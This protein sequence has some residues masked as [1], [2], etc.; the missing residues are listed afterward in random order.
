ME[1][2]KQGERDQHQPLLRQHALRFGENSYLMAAP[3]ATM[4]EHNN[5]RSTYVESG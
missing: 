3:F 2:A 5:S 4:Q 1:E